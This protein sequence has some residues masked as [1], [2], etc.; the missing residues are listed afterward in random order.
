MVLNTT[1][2]YLT[3]EAENYIPR[4]ILLLYE[5]ISFVIDDFFPSVG[6]GKCSGH[7]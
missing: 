5:K 7:A 3:T 1:A 6:Y 4:S 2:L